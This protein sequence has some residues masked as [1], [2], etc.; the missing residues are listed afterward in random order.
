MRLDD[1]QIRY[2][3]YY[4]FEERKNDIPQVVDVSEY[5]GGNKLVINCTQLDSRT[6]KEK[7]RILAEWCEF[8]I[9]HPKA[10]KVLKFGTRMPQDLFDA[11]C[12]QQNLE[13]FEVKWGA[14]K[15]LSAIQNLSKLKLLYLGSGAGV[16]SI[17][18]IAKLKKSNWA[19]R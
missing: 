15:N 6:A 16:E 18:S 13:H 14:Y 19:L 5:N 2:G 9:E 1:E 11:V 3:F 4:F 17:A 7:K 8:L 12:H 10:L